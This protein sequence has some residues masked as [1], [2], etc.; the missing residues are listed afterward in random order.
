MLTGIEWHTR[1]QQTTKSI[2]R[3]LKGQ[4]TDFQ[5]FFEFGYESMNKVKKRE[6]V[7][8]I[9]KRFV[10]LLQNLGLD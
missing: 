1:F 9:K 5:F 2:P 6:I 8:M 3:P 7:F 4:S 10:F